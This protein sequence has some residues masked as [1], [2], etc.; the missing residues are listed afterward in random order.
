MSDFIDFLNEMLHERLSD[1]DI[2]MVGRIESFDGQKM[3]ADVTPLLKK[4]SGE[5]EIEYS[6]L[7]DIPIN[8]LNAGDYYIR[9][10][11]KKG[12]LVQIVFSTHDIE[13]TLRDKKPLASEKIFSSENAFIIGGIAKTAW[14]PPAEF[15]KEGLLIGHKNGKA[16]TQYKEDML[17]H[18]F[19]DSII[20]LKQDEV[21]INN[22][23][24]TIASSS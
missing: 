9:P 4:R 7:K 10:E 2:S 24:L 11:Y 16:F 1:I 18:K 12:D 20:V 23:A 13:E 14:S 3:R 15:S 19:G 17:V 5:T 8:F 22:G 21:N 6:V